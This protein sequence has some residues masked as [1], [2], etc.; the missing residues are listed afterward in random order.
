VTWINVRWKTEV[1]RRA[2]TLDIVDEAD[3]DGIETQAEG[4][5]P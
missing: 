4:T 3:E 2:S 1:G 5:T